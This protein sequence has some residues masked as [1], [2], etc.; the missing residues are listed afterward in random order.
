MLCISDISFALSYERY[1]SSSSKKI[2]DSIK[3]KLMPNIAEH[4]QKYV[5]E[6][7]SITNS[8]MKGLNPFSFREFLNKVEY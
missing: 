1:S 7:Q 2:L 5:K 8:S 4:V 3:P 6:L